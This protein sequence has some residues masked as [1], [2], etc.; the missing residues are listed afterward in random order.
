MP[1]PQGVCGL[2]QQLRNYWRPDLGA[3]LSALTKSFNLLS[4][5][6]E[7]FQILEPATDQSAQ[8]QN[9]YICISSDSEPKQ[10]L[11]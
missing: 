8:T 4:D 6:L 11:E 1:L 3:S 10:V 9:Y 2:T 5:N 7:L